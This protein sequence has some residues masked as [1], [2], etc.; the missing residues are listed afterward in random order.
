MRV[1]LPKQQ[2]DPPFTHDEL[3]HRR[4]IRDWVD[5]DAVAP[6]AIQFA[7]TSVDRGLMA[8]PQ[9]SLD[10]GSELEVAIGSAAFGQLPSEF[11]PPPSNS[12]PPPKTFELVVV[13]CP[14]NGNGAHTHLQSHQL[15][16]LKPSKPG[17]MMKMQIRTEIASKMRVTLRRN[18]PSR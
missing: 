9:E 5:G 17:G 1:G 2:G 7:E 15:E 6:E 12:N 13:H 16:A 11:K 18:T 14:E 3:L 10:R 8:T 4:L